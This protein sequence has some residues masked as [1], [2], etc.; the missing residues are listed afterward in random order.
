M[1]YHTKFQHLFT[2][3]L[4]VLLCAVVVGASS[5]DPRGRPQ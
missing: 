3:L 1:I 4:P 5:R 2:A